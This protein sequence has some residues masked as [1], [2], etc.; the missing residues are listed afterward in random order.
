[1]ICAAPWSSSSFATWSAT[2]SASAGA[3]DSDPYWFLYEGTPGGAN[4]NSAEAESTEQDGPEDQR[5]G[6]TDAAQGLAE[7]PPPHAGGGAE[8]IEAE[9]GVEG[10]RLAR[11]TLPDLVL[12]D[13]NIPD[14]DGYEVTLR[15]RG[16]PARSATH[17]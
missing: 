4:R 1:M 10:I 6:D 5:L 8:Q 16:T 3:A 12:V 11:D 9:G 14:L 7:G 13:I 17:S 15:L 2:L